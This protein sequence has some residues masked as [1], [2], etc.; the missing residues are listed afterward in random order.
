MQAEPFE[1]Q[2][3]SIDVAVIASVSHAD[4]WIKQGMHCH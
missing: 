4:K 3:S 2:D 1:G